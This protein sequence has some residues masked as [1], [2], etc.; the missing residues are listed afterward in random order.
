MMMRRMLMFA[1]GGA[2]DVAD[3]EEEAGHG[4]LLSGFL[5]AAFWVSV[6]RIMTLLMRKMMIMIMI[7]R[8]MMMMIMMMIM[9]IIMMM[10]MMMWTIHWSVL[11]RMLRKSLDS[12]LND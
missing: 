6:I 3:P 8:I 1:E 7:L 2:E 9:M 4:V 11:T 12:V 10:L 5:L